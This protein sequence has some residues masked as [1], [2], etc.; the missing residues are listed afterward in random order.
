M[1][2]LSK[3]IGTKTYKIKEVVVS[4][5]KKLQIEVKGT[6]KGSKTQANEKIR[7]DL[8]INLFATLKDNDGPTESEK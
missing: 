5:E 8:K 7:E 1:Q 6:N 2:S 4:T 3:K